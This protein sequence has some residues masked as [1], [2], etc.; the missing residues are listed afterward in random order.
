MLFNEVAQQRA[1]GKWHSGGV[2]RPPME[3]GDFARTALGV[4]S[5]VEYGPP[6]RAADMKERTERAVAWLR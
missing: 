4:R 1:D 2:M 6:A 3:D 5:L